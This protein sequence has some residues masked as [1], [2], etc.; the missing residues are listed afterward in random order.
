MKNPRILLSLILIVVAVTALFVSY[1]F[2]N[3]PTEEMLKKI[4]EWLGIRM[5][6]MDIFGVTHLEYYPDGKIRLKG[7]YKESPVSYYP[8]FKEGFSQSPDSFFQARVKNG[9]GASLEFEI[10]GGD[11]YLKD[12]RLYKNNKNW[13]HFSFDKDFIIKYIRTFGD[14][15]EIKEE[16]RYPSGNLESIITRK[17]ANMDEEYYSPSGDKVFKLVNGNGY[18]A[19]WE[20]NKGLLILKKY[21]KDRE[22]IKTYFFISPFIPLKSFKYL[23]YKIYCTEDFDDDGNPVFNENKPVETDANGSLFPVFLFKTED[24]KKDSIFKM[25][26]VKK[27]QY[28]SNSLE[29]YHKRYG[30]YPEN[31]N[32]I[33][34]ETGNIVYRFYKEEINN[35]LQDT[36]K[37]PFYYHVDREGK[38]CSFGSFGADGKEGGTDY[39]A[40]ISFSLPA[41]AVDKKN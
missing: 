41:D 15:E 18:R 16:K 12:I 37:N 26:T 24:G 19:N 7:I 38:S 40:D 21:E 36:W 8:L 20:I 9:T 28:I 10:S 35:I 22:V 32:S 25:A 27:L 1:L 17:N 11:Y 6:I 31:L 13:K 30:K 33:L 5:A 23:D 2:K 3:P 39:N 34:P 29:A 4:P 14:S